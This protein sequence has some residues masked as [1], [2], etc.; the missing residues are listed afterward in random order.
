MDLRRQV[1]FSDTSRLTLTDRLDLL[2]D[3][4]VAIPASA[5]PTQR[6]D[7]QAED[8][9]RALS[10]KA[11][12]KTRRQYL[13]TVSANAV[14]AAQGFNDQFVDLFKGTSWFPYSYIGLRASVPIYDGGQKRNLQQ[15]QQ[16]QVIKNE[17]NLQTI[18]ANY[19]YEAASAA[20]AFADARRTVSLQADNLRIAEALLEQAQVRLANQLGTTQAVTDAE[21]TLQ[22]SQFNYL[23]ALYDLA[24]ARLDWL[25]ANGRL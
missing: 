16:L 6:P 3:T 15:Q 10:A 25:R 8:L 9:Q 11:I 13:P 17:T 14:L 21:T 5:D 18:Q 7:Y 2:A 12:E 23:Q 4:T 24:N 20:K 1:G 19:R 22:D